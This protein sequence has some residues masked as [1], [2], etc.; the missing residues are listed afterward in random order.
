MYEKCT[1]TRGPTMNSGPGN[2]PPKLGGVAA[3]SAD[4]VVP[5]AEMFRLEEPPRPRSRS[6][7]PPNL[8]GEL[9]SCEQGIHK[10]IRTKTGEQSYGL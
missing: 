2:S 1:I 4:G 6:G 10:Q 3:R 9:G 8:G 7:T 5:H